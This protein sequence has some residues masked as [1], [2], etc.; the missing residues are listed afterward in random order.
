MIIRFRFKTVPIC[1]V[2][3]E[4]TKHIHDQIPWCILLVDNV[5]LVDEG[6]KDA[7][8]KLEIW[9]NTLKAKRFKLNRAHTE[10]VKCNFSYK[11]SR[12]KG[13]VRMDDTE[14]VKVEVFGKQAL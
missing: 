3:D 11:V 13:G 10:Y 6:R 12:N 8:L 7:N 4:L 5:V 2:M 9:E 14:I 1:L